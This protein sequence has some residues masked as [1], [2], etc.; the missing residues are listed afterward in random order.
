MTLHCRAPAAASAFVVGRAPVC[1]T[2]SEASRRRPLA[3]RAS[4]NILRLE[5][6]SD[7]IGH[8]YIVDP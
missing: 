2:A 1:A 4:Q 6:Q 7:F 5:K 8:L 3:F